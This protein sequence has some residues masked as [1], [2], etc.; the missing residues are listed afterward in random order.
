MCQ[1][2]VIGVV[3]CTSCGYLL[4]VG[5]PHSRPG[6][7]PRGGLDVWLS[8]WCADKVIKGLCLTLE[9]AVASVAVDGIAFLLLHLRS[10]VGHVL[11]R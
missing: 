11:Q 8:A 7:N 10:H 5:W 9:V 2:M 3:L 1:N 6:P 4:L